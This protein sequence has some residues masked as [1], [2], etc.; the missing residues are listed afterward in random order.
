MGLHAQAND[1]HHLL[2]RAAAVSNFV[3]SMLA[4]D[5][6]ARSSES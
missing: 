2:R 6:V 3:L 5:Y 4:S 1:H